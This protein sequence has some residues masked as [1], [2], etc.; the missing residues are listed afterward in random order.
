M[1]DMGLGWHIA[2]KSLNFNLGNI[3]IKSEPKQGSI[4]YFTIS[5][6]L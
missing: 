4:F 1:K 3:W 6:H 2:K 5:K